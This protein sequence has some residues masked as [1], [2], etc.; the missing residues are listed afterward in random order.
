MLFVNSTYGFGTGL[1]AIKIMIIIPAIDLYQ[2]K[3]VRLT[4]GD[5]ANCKVYGD[6]PVSVARKWKEKGAQWLHLVD[7]SAAFSQGSNKEVIAEIIKG[8]G[9][10]VEV[11]GGIRS[12]EKVKELVSIGAKRLV[13]GTKAIDPNFL[14]QA[15]EITNGRIAVAVDEKAGKLAIKGWQK[16]IDLPIG[17]YLNYL[18]GQGVKWVIYTD[19]SRDGTLEGPNLDKLKQF[20]SDD[21]LNLIFSGG[22]S[23]LEDIKSLKEAAP[24]VAG[25]VVGKALYEE[26]ISL[27]DAIKV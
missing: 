23:C 19:I 9:I 14:Q 8:V 5:R 10:S 7:L 24:S 25:V 20:L 15:L 6:D 17:Q 16:S 13:L 18:K 12:L 4:R 26:K 3:V 11:G 1:R 2:K 22:V 21:Q 27:E